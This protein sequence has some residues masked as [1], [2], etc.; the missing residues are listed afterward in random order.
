MVHPQ[1]CCVWLEFGFVSPL[2]GGG[3]RYVSRSGRQKCSRTDFWWKAVQGSCRSTSHPSHSL[4]TFAFRSGEVRR[5]LLDLDFYGALTHW[6]CFLSA[7]VC[8]QPTSSLIGKVSALVMPLCVC[9]TPYRVLWRTRMVQINFQG[10]PFR[11]CAVGVGCSVLSV[12]SQF[13][14]NQSQYVVV[15]GC[16]SKLLNVVSGVP[17]ESVLGSQMFIFTPR[18]V[19]L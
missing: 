2:I 7:E 3:V 6:V 13:I 15:D 8:F 9:H 10:I 4:T 12:L 19:F 11:L 18:S 17:K 16:R 14:S 1:V 5:L